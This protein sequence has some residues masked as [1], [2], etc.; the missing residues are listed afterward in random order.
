MSQTK[1]K[2]WF[3]FCKN[4]ILLERLSDGTYTVPTGDVPPV[5]TA[6]STHILHVATMDGTDM[7]AFDTGHPL[8]ADG[9]YVVCGLRQSYY[10]LSQD[11]YLKAGKCHELVYWDGNTKYC[12]VCG[13]PMAMHTD[14]SK[15]C[16]K[17][18]KEVW[19]QLN[20]A[21]IVLIHRGDEVLLVHALNFRSEFYGL[22]AGFVETGETLEEAVRRE[23]REET[24]LEIKNLTYFGSQPWPY[25]CG[26]MV[27]FMA[28]YDSGELHLQ[29]SELRNG[30][31][32]R[33]D[34]LPQLPEKLSIARRIIDHWL[35]RFDKQNDCQK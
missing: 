6:D 30:G 10:K 24:S 7:Y 26:L 33:Y 31:W 21:V 25:P 15:C 19:P 14:I 3:V 22:V 29:H 4:D 13:S 16:T 32:F 20:T 23:V 9:R 28:E 11:I 8:E 35:T 5:E 18:G 12:G 17:C 34:N 2:L 27:G 1:D